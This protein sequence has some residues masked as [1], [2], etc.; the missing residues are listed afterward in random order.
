MLVILERLPTEDLTNR[1]GSDSEELETFDDIRGE[2]EA[3]DS[4]KDAT[5]APTKEDLQG[6]EHDDDDD[7]DVQQDEDDDDDVEQD[8]DDDDGTQ[9]SAEDI[10]ETDDLD[11][12]RRRFLL[13]NELELSKF[14]LFGKSPEGLHLLLSKAGKALKV[15]KM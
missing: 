2:E 4:D 7:N 12:L 11:G 15:S 8:E 1:D 3:D 10:A 5:W 6:V 9:E 14:R 13:Q